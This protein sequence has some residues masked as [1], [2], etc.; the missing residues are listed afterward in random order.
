MSAFYLTCFLLGA[1]ALIAQLLL[2]AL[3]ADAEHHASMGDHGHGGLDLL[4]VRSIAAASGFFGLIGFGMT[5]AGFGFA[6]ALTAAL[7][8]GFGA[9]VAI[10]SLMR[11][12]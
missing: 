5:R 4:S 10:A 12:S 1:L 3:G 6:I 8:S 7:I 2:G 11:G 9:A